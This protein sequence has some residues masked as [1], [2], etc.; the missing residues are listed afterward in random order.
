LLVQF[1]YL[2]RVLRKIAQGVWRI[3][4]SEAAVVASELAKEGGWIAGG[5]ER[6]LGE[7]DV[8]N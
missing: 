4:L 3:F 1:P 7:A 5:L 2:S 8:E 6:V